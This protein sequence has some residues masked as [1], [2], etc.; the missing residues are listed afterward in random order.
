MVNFFCFKILRTKTFAK[1]DEILKKQFNFLKLYFFL[2]EMGEVQ[3]KETRDLELKSGCMG[4][5]VQNFSD[6]DWELKSRCKR[7]VA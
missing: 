6:R 3:G 4:K 7:N 1:S 5:V 2:R